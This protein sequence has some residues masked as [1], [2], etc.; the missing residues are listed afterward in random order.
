MRAVLESR[1]PWSQGLYIPVDETMVFWTGLG[2]V[3]LTYIPRKP[4]PLGIMF[5]VRVLAR[6]RRMLHARAQWTRPQSKE[7]K[8]YV[9]E[10]KATTALHPA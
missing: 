3:H 5:K 8:R 1:P 4:S 7:N 2:P 6:G 10:Y 9:Q